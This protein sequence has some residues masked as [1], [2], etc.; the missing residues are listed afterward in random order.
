VSWFGTTSW[1]NAVGWPLT[2]SRTGRPMT[3]T[4]W[5]DYGWNRP[6][7]GMRNTVGSGQAW[8]RWPLPSTVHRPICVACS[9]RLQ[10]AA[11]GRCWSSSD[12][13]RPADCSPS[14]ISA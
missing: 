2:V 14:R 9:T 5:P 11:P 7:A 4:P 1:P 6:A 3:P 8:K 10:E 12:S 13:V